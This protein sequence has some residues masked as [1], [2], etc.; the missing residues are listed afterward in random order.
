MI[1]IKFEFFEKQLKKTSLKILFSTTE[2]VSFSF[3]Q[4]IVHDGECWKI[5]IKLNRPNTFNVSS[6]GGINFYHHH[7][8]SHETNT[9]CQD[10]FY[11]ECSTGIELNEQLRGTILESRGP[12]TWRESTCFSNKHTVCTLFCYSRNCSR[13]AKTLEYRQL[14]AH[15]QPIC[16]WKRGN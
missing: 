16:K 10:N 4:F 9:Y 11:F 3:L 2:I 12:N 6:R 7:S 5:D 1:I 8:S 14:N 15:R 13:L